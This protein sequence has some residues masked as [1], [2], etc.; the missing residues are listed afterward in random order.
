[1]E[2]V[3]IILILINMAIHKYLS[4]LYDLGTL[5]YPRAFILYA[6]FQFL[7]WFISLVFIF[8]WL[9]GIIITVLSMFNII[10]LTFLWPLVIPW[11]L[12]LQKDTTAVNVNPIYYGLWSLSVLALAILTIINFFISEYKSLNPLIVGFLNDNYISLI[13][14]A[15]MSNLIRYAIRVKLVS[16]QN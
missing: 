9:F 16:R 4:T 7:I 11:V 10:Q 14:F 15:I 1:M 2:I 6:N 5:S 3:I 8:G 12:R 13:V